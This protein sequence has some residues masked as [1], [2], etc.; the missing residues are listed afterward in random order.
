MDLFIKLLTYINLAGAVHALIQ[1]G[2]LCLTKRGNRRAHRFMALFLIAIAI[3]MANG[4]ISLLGLYDRWPALAVLM[5]SVVL[6]YHPLFYLYIRAIT[7]ADRRGTLFDILHGAPFLLGMLIWG[8]YLSL[9]A[10]GTAPSGIL[11]SVI[12]SP[13]YFVLSVSVLQSIAYITGI[14]RLLRK[15]SER[16]KSSFSTLDAVNLGWLRRRLL[17]F[18][19]IW[20]IGLALVAAVR[21]EAK[22]MVLVG[23]IVAFLT[24]LNTFAAGYRAMLQPEIFLG[25]PEAVPGRRYERSSL[26]P[27][28]AVLYK[29]RLLEMMESRRPYLDPE[30]TLP[31]LAKALDIPVAHLS[32]VINDLF[33][34]NFYEFINGYR[35]EEAK[36]RL[37]APGSKRA[38]LIAVA[39]DCGFNSLATF[40]RVFKEL[41]GRTPSDFRKN[42]PAA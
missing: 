4:M 14:I 15:H 42:Q 32:R 9:P 23:Q 12:R 19:A 22:A 16:V 34:R 5:G 17:A 2:V 36:R 29:A 37:A 1:S 25:P 41:A 35:V 30:I 26:T 8:A 27:D 39:L 24:A 33:G 13:W 10:G 3:G 11:G 21:F 31:K 38:K 40:N 6:T 28:N 7:A 18:I 20:G